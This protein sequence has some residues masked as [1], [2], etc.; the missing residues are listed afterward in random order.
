MIDK[1]RNLQTMLNHFPSWM[2][3]KKRYNKSNGGA[4]LQAY[5]DEVDNANTAIKEY[6]D[7]F[8]LL[9]YYG[10]EKD[11]PAYMY[12]ALIGTKTLSS[13]KVPMLKHNEYLTDNV[14]DFYKNL[15][16]YILY[17]DD[18]LIIHPSFF[19]SDT[20]PNG[21]E[22][23]I[24]DT[25]KYSSKLYYRHI[26]NVFDEFALFSG[27]K[28][29]ENESNKE[30]SNRIIQQFKNF[31]NASNDGLKNAIKNALYNIVDIS[32]DSI[33][34]EQPNANNLTDNDVYDEL[35]VH[36]R[37]LFRTKKW[38]TSLWEHGF[39]SVDLLPRKWDKQPDEYQD[40]TGSRDDLRIDFIENISMSDT[41]NV[42]V[43]GY[44]KSKKAI[45]EYL[46]NNNIETD[47]KLSLTKIKNTISP[48]K[49]EY[50][51]I[52][53][54]IIKLNAEKIHI[55]GSKKY[56][57]KN[58]Y[59]LEDY[60][61]E[62]DGATKIER[63]VLI[64]NKDYQLIFEPT[65]N[66]SDMRISQIDIV[67][68]T[69][70]TKSLLIENDPFIF[71][72]KDI[73]NKN[74]LAH[75][76][77]LNDMT[78]YSNL[79]N[80]NGGFTLDSASDVGISSIALDKSMS[81]GMINVDCECKEADITDSGS[82]VKYSNFQLS[83]TGTTL[84][85][86]NNASSASI[87]I[88]L[89]KCRSFS[90]RLDAS[91]DAAKQGAIYVTIT[92]NGTSGRR[93]LYTKAS[94]ISESYSNAGKTE[95]FIQ[96][97]GQN[98]VSISNIKTA[99]Y[100]VKY[101][102]DSGNVI[103]NVMYTMLPSIISDNTL[104]IE[105]TAYTAY[106]PIVK[107][108]HI[109]KSLL[110]AK[111]IV[112]FSTSSQSW[113]FVD[114]TCNVTLINKTDGVTVNNYTTKATYKNNTNTDAYIFLDISN[115]SNIIS[116]SPA[117]KHKFS[118][119]TRDFIILSP[120][121]EIDSITIN[122]DN[123]K[124]VF[125][126][127]LSS[128]LY[129]NEVD[130]EVYI[131]RIMSSF[132]LKHNRKESLVSISKNDLTSKADIFEYTNLD[133]GVSGLY[134]V[135]QSKNNTYIG[136]S[137]DRNFQFICLYPASSQ[138]YIA[139]NTRHILRKITDNVSLDNTFSPVIS[140]S[141]KFLFVICD[142][143]DINK[144]RKTTVNFYDDNEEKNWS[145]SSETPIRIT[146]GIDFENEEIY[147]ADIS[148][149]HDRYILSNE[150][151]L[152]DTYVINGEE[153]ELSEFIVTAPDGIEI[154]YDK[155]ECTEELIA[156]NDGFNK[157][158]Y[159]NVIKIISV[160][161]ENNIMLPP[162]EYKLI[163][164]EGVLAW[165][166]D[167]YIGKTVTV[168]YVMNKPVSLVFVDEDILYEK[169][170]YN[171]D[172]Y[173]KI[174][175]IRFLGV[176]DKDV[177]HLDFTENP[178]KIIIQQ[179]ND[180]FYASLSNDKKSISIS[181]VKTPNKIVVHNG[182]LYEGGLEYY[183]FADKYEDNDSR[184]KDLEMINT[185]ILGNKLL[186]RMRS[187]NYLPHSS[188]TSDIMSKSSAFDFT[189]KRYAGISEF[190]SLTACDTF[191][192]WVLFN[193]NAEMSAGHNGYGMNFKSKNTDYPSYAI[194][195]ITDKI[196]NGN[197]ISI[198]KNGLCD[199][200]ICK[201]SKADKLPLTKDIFI[202]KDNMVK[203]D[204][205]GEYFYSIINYNK[206]PETRYFMLIYGSS[207]MIDDIVAMKYTSTKDMI[208][209]HKKNIDKLN[210]KITE[211][212]SADTIKQL[213][214]N[215]DNAIYNYTERS[216]TD[217][218]II[219][220]SMS[221]AYGHTKVA[222]IE[223]D[224]CIIINAR[225]KGFF[226]LAEDNAAQITTQPIFIRSRKTVSALLIKVNDVMLDNMSL[227]NI[228]VYGCSS[229][230]GTYKKIKSEK[231][232]NV[233]TISARQT[234]SYIKVVI[235][236][237]S[238]NKL[239]N[240]ISVYAKYAET[241][242]GAELTSTPNQHGTLTSMIYDIGSNAKFMPITPDY[243]INERGKAE[244]YYRGAR[245]NKNT[246]VFTDWYKINTGDDE[247]YNH[248]LDNYRL[249]QFKVNINSQDT[250]IAIKNFAIKIVG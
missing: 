71:K 53:S 82:Y 36:N 99:M 221:T 98:P 232:T 7:L 149:L 47:I 107:S 222:D 211:K 115:F 19:G 200:F 226:I 57:G 59:Y 11:I 233:L 185:S 48:Q 50:K 191:G 28:R 44:K 120:G 103:Q 201:E 96:K 119:S 76:T 153:A 101:R 172:A 197:I 97:A 193:M 209:S 86:I 207:C 175:T 89:P 138:E 20:P 52:A 77:S 51:I 61:T 35:T 16:E 24:D 122:G 64:A 208:N 241:N 212:L 239:I 125:D 130:Y 242:D 17:Q 173:D 186:F 83:A 190:N 151:P 196:I 105:L 23:I 160:Y 177:L 108:I 170:R 25:Y 166:N 84:E 194:L 225:Y 85:S 240:S 112:D 213:K 1:T 231:N 69:N 134:I 244:F 224:Q 155:Y 184:T 72:N 164:K 238:K 180:V 5:N 140:F 237:I 135:E 152:N 124:T 248:V 163:E 136:N 171:V 157:L 73:V 13:I 113:L 106:A 141:K 63:N 42:S 167:K 87:N 32:D 90:F 43:T 250:E 142:V 183:F 227:F 8:F 54:D 116:S 216:S 3:I 218:S 2:D 65:S 243:S 127:S 39:K 187:T 31:P 168:N 92:R 195:E 110:G 143:S 174:Q 199:V 159:S 95:I 178:D 100:D 117:L 121:E 188:M 58:T 34:I 21:I 56:S 10:K 46:K 9:N 12:I 161:D 158:H 70:T 202:E 179:D 132:I 80:Y 249:I 198:V 67:D 223:L 37:D 147:D 49:I 156:E 27:L 131:S 114:S 128:I 204:N 33:I 219:T 111:Y 154:K 88:T 68:S 79:K 104:S 6:Q 29:Y 66:Y 150:I 38:D 137:Y 144:T 214:F 220:T 192:H 102:L 247:K 145:M 206:E 94:N 189:D 129:N 246:V 18:A 245:E 78:S 14:D 133:A 169:I 235:T 165:E 81:F 30:L 215:Y 234:K 41:T 75:I 228:E 109:G 91:N 181:Q 229:K 55:I 22:Y 60:V 93:I 205:E 146:S 62:L 4:L 123:K 15:S 45:T 148:D 139:Y 236:D 126:K 118:G 230:D 210:L 217:P 203:L 162:S 74:V 176:K 26:W 40:G 182:Y